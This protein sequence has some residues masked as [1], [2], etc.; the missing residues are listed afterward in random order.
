MAAGLHCIKMSNDFTV[1]SLRIKEKQ[2]ENSF[3]A[4]ACFAQGLG[5]IPEQHKKREWL[6]YR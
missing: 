3:N 1:S 4:C 5:A 6:S 2:T